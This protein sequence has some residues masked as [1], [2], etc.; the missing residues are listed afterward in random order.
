MID[1]KFWTDAKITELSFSARLLYIGLWQYADDEGLFKKD[2]R[3]IKM[4]LFPDQKFPLEK[5]FD[6]LENAGFFRLGTLDGETVVEIRQFLTH[7]KVNRPTPSKLRENTVFSEGSVSPQESSVRTHAQVKIREVKIREVKRG[8]SVSCHSLSPTAQAPFVPPDWID[9]K[10]WEEFRAMRKKKRAA[11][12]PYAEALVVTELQ[13]LRTAG[14]D[15]AA[16]L[17][18][19]IRNNWTDVYPLKDNSANGNRPT[20]D[21]LRAETDRALKA[22]L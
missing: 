19:S 13:K 1:P 17:E 8:D 9:A 15:V 22:G 2:L 6:E 5:C 16:I 11:M 7:Q 4:E 12:T 18:Q 21:K 3:N 20:V 14:G 10:I